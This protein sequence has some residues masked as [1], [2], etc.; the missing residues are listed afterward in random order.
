MK[1][2]F[3]KFPRLKRYY[4]IYLLV[5]ILCSFLIILATHA[6][7]DLTAFVTNNGIGNAELLILTTLAIFG[8]YE[9]CT[10]FVMKIITNQIVEYLRQE[11]YCKISDTIL[12]TCPY[13]MKDGD[14]YSLIQDDTDKSI[15][16]L[17][18]TIPNM[19]YQI[20]RFILVILYIVFIDVYVAMIYIV[21]GLVS[22]FIQ[23]FF[24]KMIRES[25]FKTKIKETKMNA[26]LNNVLKNRLVLKLNDN[27]SYINDIYEN[28]AMLYT[29]AYLS[30]ESIALPFR[31]IGI[32]VGLFPIL[33]I[34]VVGYF[35]IIRGLLSFTSFMAIYYVCQYVVYD[36]LHFADYL[37][38]CAKSRINLDRLILFISTNRKR[39]DVKEIGDI[40][41][42]NVSFSY[43]DNDTP[44][45]S[46]FNLDIQEGSKVAI[47]GE[48]GCG[49]T[50]V[51]NL[52]AGILEPTRGMIK[53]GVVSYMPQF[54][55]LFTDTIKRN[56]TCWKNVENEKYKHV[57]K[58][59]NIYDFLEQ[60][61]QKDETILYDNAM[62]LSGGQKQRIA[63]SRVLL[64]HEKIILFDEAFSSLDNCNAN[65]TIEKIIRE[66]H[67]LTM[68]FSIHQLELLHK[69]DRIIEMHAGKIIFDG[70]YEE[71]LA[72]E[73]K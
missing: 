16:F 46:N 44:I 43:A 32:F 65:E 73:K 69:M 49:K 38:E 18:E 70:T 53:S 34:C 68:I 14:L 4:L 24:S 36:Q 55:F 33:S 52:I 47:I 28:D 22:I 62:N 50:T 42:K 20:T 48:S 56:I 61:P 60:L 21:T 40:S 45:L 27:F 54:P 9:L 29:K 67:D 30:T 57:L 71:W 66:Y 26:T 35:M 2:S 3:R 13:S 64:N 12:S 17:S 59:S 6:M 23:R 72:Y 41:F 63:L 5:C 39:K 58:I 7:S 19:M 37:S 10:Y 1:N 25:N 15:L 8:L 31:M 11:I 51:L